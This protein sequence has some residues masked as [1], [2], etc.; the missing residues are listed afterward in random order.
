MSLN[1]NTAARLKV[2]LEK[3]IDPH[4]PIGEGE[5]GYEAFEKGCDLL[6]KLDETQQNLILTLLENYQFINVLEYS[7]LCTQAIK[8]ID[9]GRFS[10]IESISIVP[11]ITKKDHDAGNYKSGLGIVNNYRTKNFKVLIGKKLGSKCDLSPKC[12][13]SPFS[14][15]NPRNKRDLLIFVDDFVGTGK[16]ATKAIDDF[17]SN[18]SRK[19]ENF[20]LTVLGSMQD[21]YNVLQKKDYP[22][23]TVKKFNRGITDCP[24]FKKKKET[25]ELMKSIEENLKNCPKYSLGYEKSEALVT[26]QRTP[27]NTFPVFW[28]SETKGGLEWPAPFPRFL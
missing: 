16:T 10:D 12:F 22:F 1:G 27:N 15:S 21:G 4:F 25:I 26:M 7:S 6:A 19:K 3:V 18:S 9:F 8:N 23:Y 28:D 11:C 13:S 20:C 24:I 14:Y 5:V 2:I 17:F